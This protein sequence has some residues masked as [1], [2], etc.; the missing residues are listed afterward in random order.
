MLWILCPINILKLK[1]SISLNLKQN[2]EIKTSGIEKWVF[3]KNTLLK[4][5]INCNDQQI[6]VELHERYKRYRNVLFT[7]M[8][9]NKQ[10][11]CTK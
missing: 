9:E 3:V 8:K 4:N 7:L 2:L 6:K 1:L 5:S 11:Y 10:T